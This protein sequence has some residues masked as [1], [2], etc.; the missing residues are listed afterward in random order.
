MAAKRILFGLDGSAQCLYAAEIC[1]TLAE[2]NKASITAQH[3][4]NSIGLWEFLGFEEPGFVGSGVFFSAHEHIRRQ[5]EEVS[6]SLIESYETHVAQRNLDEHEI[7][8]DD[9]HTVREILKRAKD[10]DLIVVGHKPSAMGS[11]EKDQRKFPRT[12][13]AGLLA[14]YSSKPVLTVQ[15][16]CD[17]PGSITLVTSGS[18]LQSLSGHEE[19]GINL[20]RSITLL[21][22]NCEAKAEMRVWIEP[23][24]REQ[25]EAQIEELTEDLPHPLAC[26]IEESAT[27]SLLSWWNIEKSVK[28]DELVVLPTV[29]LE[30]SRQTIFGVDANTLLAYCSLPA[31]MF[32]PDEFALT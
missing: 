27:G 20:L 2:R 17:F 16:A 8:V 6:K 19:K 15:H 24:E 10:H 22:A 29:E 13:V 28:K 9:G 4:I 23:P 25:T 3:V 21:A 32:W 14:S 1:W 7:V 5:L 30:R 31:V 11:P 18:W 26:T 12:S